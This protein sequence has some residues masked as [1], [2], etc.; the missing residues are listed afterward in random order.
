MSK[1][2]EYV[3]LFLFKGIEICGRSDSGSNDENPA[4]DIILTKALYDSRGGVVLHNDDGM[5]LVVH[6]ANIATSVTFETAEKAIEITSDSKDRPDFL[7]LSG[8][9]FP[10]A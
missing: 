10:E 7:N 2:V 9:E 5:T 3:L 1:A 8:L 6:A 4:F